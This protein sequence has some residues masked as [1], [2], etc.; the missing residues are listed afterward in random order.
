MVLF[1][2]WDNEQGPAFR[3][4]LS[5][6]EWGAWENGKMGEFENTLLGVDVVFR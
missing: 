6:I 2:A 5:S 4:T 1:E 3:A